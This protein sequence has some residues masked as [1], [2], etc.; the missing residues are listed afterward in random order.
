MNL[1]SLYILMILTC[2][3]TFACKFS[4]QTLSPIK[5]PPRLV[6][7]V[8]V[9]DIARLRYRVTWRALRNKEAHARHSAR[10]RPCHS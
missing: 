9:P 8:W 4:S 5:M 3:V 10:P 7:T 1:E 6:A 2:F